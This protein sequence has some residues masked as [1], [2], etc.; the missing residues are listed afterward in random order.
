ML[1]M[2]AEGEGLIIDT[3]A[4]EVLDTIVQEE[5]A[6]LANKSPEEQEAALPLLLTRVE[7]RAVDEVKERRCRTPPPSPHLRL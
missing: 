3:V 6:E 1:A 7:Q 2:A 4:Q 5:L